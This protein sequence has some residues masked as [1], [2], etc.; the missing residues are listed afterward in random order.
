MLARNNNLGSDYHE[1]GRLV[2][3]KIFG[4]AIDWAESADFLPPDHLQNILDS[5]VNDTEIPKITN[6]PHIT[7]RESI[8]TMALDCVVNRYFC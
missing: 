6:L 2:E 1:F 8:S 5:I 4:E 7:L 3:K